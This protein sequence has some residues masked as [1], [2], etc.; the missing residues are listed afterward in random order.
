MTS[1]STESM[2]ALCRVTGHDP[3]K[4]LLELLEFQQLEPTDDGQ[5]CLQYNGDWY[6]QDG[7]PE[8]LLAALQ[9]TV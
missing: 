5:F 6:L 9:R 4:T 1:L 2:A 3:T 8:D 7:P